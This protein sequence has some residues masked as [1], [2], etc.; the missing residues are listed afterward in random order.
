M[1]VCGRRL[2]S[3]HF[4]PSLLDVQGWRLDISQ[5]NPCIWW[6][7]HR[8]KQYKKNSWIPCPFSIINFEALAL[9]EHTLR[10]AQG[11][12]LRR[13]GWRGLIHSAAWSFRTCV[14]NPGLLR[15]S[16]C[17]S[18]CT[19]I[20]QVRIYWFGRSSGENSRKNGFPRNCSLISPPI[21]GTPWGKGFLPW[22]PG[23]H[24]WRFLSLFIPKESYAD[25]ETEDS[26]RV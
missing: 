19:L 5:V 11:S 7:K 21:T 6:Q 8:R 3:L 2:I 18:E 23:P 26:E 17:V 10:K 22:L 14:Y 25:W 9:P 15:V 20:E 24:N 4:I 12:L 16:L 1:N 13:Y